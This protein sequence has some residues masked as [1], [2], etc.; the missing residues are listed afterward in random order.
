MAKRPVFIPLEP[1]QCGVR[2]LD[3]EFRWFP[4]MA[5]SQAQKSIEAL[6]ASALAAGVGPLL[7][8][9]SRSAEPLGVKLS[10]FNL[11]LREGDCVMTVETAFQGSKVFQDGQDLH[12]LYSRTSREAKTDVRIRT[13]GPL[14]EF[15]YHGDLWPLHPQNMFYDYLYLKALAQSEDLS[16]AV[17]GY[18]GFTDIA[19]NPARSLNCQARSVALWL[20]LSRLVDPRGLVRQSAAFQEAYAKLDSGVM[21]ERLL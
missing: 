2:A 8:I 6:H 19:F 21:Q 16:R 3:L 12:D 18:A 7:E 5:R 4:G 20:S 17:M 11:T 10:A 14:R 13:S 9:S 15:N 1:P